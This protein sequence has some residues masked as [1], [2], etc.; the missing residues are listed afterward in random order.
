MAAVANHVRSASS[1]LAVYDL[2]SGYT[3]LSLPT[4]GLAT[5]VSAKTVAD[6]VTAVQSAARAIGLTL[7]KGVMALEVI[8]EF[9]LTNQSLVEFESRRILDVILA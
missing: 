3:T 8:P 5:N 9:R 2:D 4:A 7:P 6:E 1:G